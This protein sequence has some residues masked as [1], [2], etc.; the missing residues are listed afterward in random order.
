MNESVTFLNAIDQEFVPDPNESVFLTLFKQYER[1]IF[2]SIITAF[3]LDLFIKD[4]YGGDVDTIHNVRQIQQD[5]DGNY[6]GPMRYKSTTNATTAENTPKYSKE[7][8]DSYLKDPAYIAQNAQ[9]SNDRKA[10]ILIDQY[11]GNPVPINGRPQLDHLMSRKEIHNDRGRMLAGIDGIE[12][13]NSPENLMATDYSINASKNAKTTEEFIQYL[14]KGRENRQNRI[15]IIKEKL[16]S[17]KEL[18][19]AERDKLQKE[20]HKLE[21]LEA[22]DIDRLREI[23]KKAREEYEKKLAKAYYLDLS[24]PNCRR[25]YL[26]TA[27]AAGKRGIQMGARQVLGFVLTEVWFTIKDEISLLDERTPGTVLDAII[28][29]IQNGFVRAMDK[30]REIISKFGEGMVSGIMASL[31]TTLC[32]IFFTTSQNL[33]RIIRQVW[34]SIVEAAKILFFNPQQQ[35]FCDR[36]TDSMKVLASGAAVVIGTTAQ[37]AVQAKV[38]AVPHPLDTIIAT[39]CGSMCTGLLTVT[40]LFYID[41]NPFG[42]AID[43][44]YDPAIQSYQEQARLFVQYCAELKKLNIDEFTRQAEQA[45]SIAMKLCSI[46]SSSIL[47]AELKQTMKAMNITSPWGEGTLESFMNNPDQRLIFQ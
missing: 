45:Y 14:E 29:G 11:T 7:I 36:L 33:G 23:D 8:G 31:S 22:V 10:G 9:M 42:M 27:K 25:F 21:E 46:Q 15:T 35:W 39:F 2:S 44:L 28:R 26:D 4:Q 41:H 3:G 6:T 24:N 13:A 38:T 40:F 43:S 12:L 17:S 5:D 16:S 1:V 30:Y 37:E 47:N 32:N 20:L 18:S 19:I 34:S